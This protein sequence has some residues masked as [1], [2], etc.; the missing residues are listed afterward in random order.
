M[1]LAPAVLRLVLVAWA[2]AVVLG[3]AYIGLRGSAPA[4]LLLVAA[5]ACA[6]I[7]LLRLLIALL[8]AFDG[9]ASSVWGYEHETVVI[10]LALVSL[11]TPWRVEISLAGA[12]SILGWQSPLAWVALVA[13]APSLSRRLGRWDGLGLTVCGLALAGWLGWSALL[14]LT[15]G[16]SR[17]HFPFQPLDL[18]GVGWYLSL[19]AWVVAVD[20]AAGRRG[21]ERSGEASPLVVLPWAAVPGAGLVRLAR[22]ALGRIYLLAAAFLVFL[23]RLTAYTPADFAYNADGNRLPDPV[24]RTDAVAL[25]VLLALFW[26]A[27]IIHTLR[28][29]RSPEPARRPPRLESGLR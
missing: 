7:G 29:A 8:Q 24:P 12:G 1:P 10:A 27:T 17:L 5:L 9:A 22:P 23:L 15:P 3:V 20:G 2:L 14:L 25:A 4:G 28:A 18:I 26:L 21:W 11:F 6:G 16:F 19:A 13:L